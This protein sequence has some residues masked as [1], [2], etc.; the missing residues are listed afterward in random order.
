MTSVTWL[1]ISKTQSLMYFKVTVELNPVML[2]QVVFEHLNLFGHSHVRATLAN[3]FT[4]PGGSWQDNH[5]DTVH[6]HSVSYI[7]HS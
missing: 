2:V 1:W 4:C 6:A 5:P 3:F 7:L